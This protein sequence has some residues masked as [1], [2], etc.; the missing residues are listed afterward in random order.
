[1]KKNLLIVLALLGLLT[2]GCNTMKIEDYEGKSPKFVLE[3]YFDGETRAWGIVRDRFGNIRRQ[4]TVDM[5]GKW[6]GQLLVLDETFSYDDGET[7]N[8]VW[9]IRKI[10]AHTYEGKAA[11]VIGSAVGKAY[12]SALNWRYTLAL[13]IGGRTW[14]VAFDDWMFLQSDGVL[15]NRAEMSKFGITLG[16]ISLFFKKPEAAGTSKFGTV[17]GTAAE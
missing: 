4:F 5:V 7:D 2:A 14:K 3:D 9:K 15:F 16:E 13:K 6:D 10:D 8:R 12:G 17:I 1:M 11:D